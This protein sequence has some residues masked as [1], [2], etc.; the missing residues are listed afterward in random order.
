MPLLE[1]DDI[2]LMKEP[3]P[4][5]RPRSPG[6]SQACL[7]PSTWCCWS[8]SVASSSHFRKSPTQAI[9]FLTEQQKRK[10][11]VWK[12]GR[13]GECRKGVREGLCSRQRNW[14]AIKL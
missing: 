10:A 1:K 7:P 9:W 2:P 13:Q 11:D 4:H 8:F 12:Y 6:S 3:H 5:L 14:N